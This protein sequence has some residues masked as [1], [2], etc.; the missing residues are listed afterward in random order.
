MR[1][2]WLI[3]VGLIAVGLGWGRAA[4]Q[5]ATGFATPIFQQQWTSG[6][7]ITPNFWGPLANATEAKQEP[8]KEAA[9]GQR[10]VQ[11]FDKGRMEMTR[12]AITNGLLAT[13]IVTGRIQRGDATFEQHAPPAIP[14]A[15]DPDTTGATYAALATKGQQLLA[16]APDTT[17]S[18]AASLA[19]SA[20]GDVT[21]N[22]KSGSQPPAYAFTLYDGATKHNVARA[23][24][25]YRALAGLGTIGYA[26]SE[27]FVATVKVAGTPRAVLIEV[28]ERRVLTYTADNPATFQ[29]EMGNI[30]QH[31][32]QWRYGPG[33]ATTPT[34]APPTNPSATVAP[35]RPG[36]LPANATSCPI[37]YPVKGSMQ[38][39]MKTYDPPGSPT[40]FGTKPEICFISPA[41]AD[42][43]GYHAKKT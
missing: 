27:P 12:G 14:M 31:Y 35:I 4:T 30:G 34:T 17:N 6:E 33:V 15:G 24:A 39:G 2:G 7:A 38:N 32:Y 23:F 11:Y 19:L 26:I 40:Y 10:T 43:A 9:D 5:A 25:D 36:I 42:A 41:D 1:K 21:V 22:P 29:V 18:D 13:E 8:Y 3:L 16:P 28:F 37:I 20:S